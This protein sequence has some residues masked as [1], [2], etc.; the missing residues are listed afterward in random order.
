M[1][2]GSVIRIVLVLSHK[3]ISSHKKTWSTNLNRTGGLPQTG[4]NTAR[5]LQYDPRVAWRGIL[6]FW[7]SRS[8]LMA[9]GLVS[10]H[11]P[12]WLLESCLASRRETRDRRS[13]DSKATS[14]GQA[15]ASA[16]HRRHAI[17]IERVNFVEHLAGCPSA[18][19]PSNRANRA[20]IKITP[21]S[22]QEFS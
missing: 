21:I 19:S 5:S 7:S 3:Y 17:S 12:R 20:N 1:L 22:R 14:C 2:C 9:I 4:R 15:S 10:L 6:P 8:P 13:A 18:A 11:G 16:V